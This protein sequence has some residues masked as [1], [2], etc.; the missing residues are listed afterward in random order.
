MQGESSAFL[1]DGDVV[2]VMKHKLMGPYSLY[3]HIFLGKFNLRC[4]FFLNIK[5]LPMTLSAATIVK[6]DVSAKITVALMHTVF[7]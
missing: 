4:Y 3:I 7:S 2:I 1:L 5:S 6:I